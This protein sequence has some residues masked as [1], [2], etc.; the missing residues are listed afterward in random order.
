MSY[1][2]N[3][4]RLGL[5]YN[6]QNLKKLAPIATKG[7]VLPLSEYFSSVSHLVDE[8]VCLLEEEDVRLIFSKIEGRVA[9][10]WTIM[11]VPEVRMIKM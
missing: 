4:D 2:N 11:K 8:H 5:G 10:K 6:S 3:K 7:L 9:T 1:P